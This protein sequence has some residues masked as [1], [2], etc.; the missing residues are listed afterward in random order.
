MRIFLST[1]GTRGDIQP[2]IALG[3]ALLAAG[4]Q[5]ALCTA[6]GYRPFVEEH[7]V[8]YAFMDNEFLA[9]IQSPTGQAAIESKRGALEIYRKSSEILEIRRKSAET[10]RKSWKS[11]GHPPEI[12]H[13]KI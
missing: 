11:A 10:L 2:F 3:Q 9:I 4:H 7:G 5:V 13:Q 1:M 8:P 12:L 6:E